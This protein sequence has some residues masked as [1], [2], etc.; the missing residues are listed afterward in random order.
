MRNRFTLL[1]VGAL[2]LAVLL[3][4]VLRPAG[5][6]GLSLFTF[7]LLPLAAVALALISMRKREVPVFSMSVLLISVLYLGLLAL[8]FFS[9][10]D[11][12]VIG[13]SSC[14]LS[15][16]MQCVDASVDAGTPVRVEFRVRNSADG[17]LDLR[18]AVAVAS[19]DGLADPGV[20]PIPPDTVLASGE[21][22]L[23]SCTFGEV[24]LPRAVTSGTFGL[25][26]ADNQ[27]K[28]LQAIGTFRLKASRP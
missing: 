5:G 24:S 27:G 17:T 2:V 9:F 15:L 1:G 14:S 20:C 13:P 12:G 11:P 23:L 4:V 16:P 21:E 25:Q 22:L 18:A 8:G 10:F 3:A 7:L 28:P 6:S 26:F 19:I